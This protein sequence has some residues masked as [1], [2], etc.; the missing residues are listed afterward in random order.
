MRKC[1]YCLKPLDKPPWRQSRYCSQKCFQADKSRKHSK[2]MKCITCGK[3]TKVADSQFSIV[4]RGTY[5]SIRCKKKQYFIQCEICKK[6]VMSRPSEKRKYCSLRCTAKGRKGTKNGKWKGGT[7]PQARL[8]RTNQK[9]YQ[10]QQA[11]FQRDNW[12]CQMCFNRGGRLEAHHNKISLADLVK[13][14]P[15]TFQAD[16]DYFYQVENGLTLCYS[17]HNTLR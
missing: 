14:N 15:N 10:W 12:I 17:C 5:C 1:F 6:E 7:T 16:D 2:I 4:G 11:V 3:K 13:N 9:Y 8:V